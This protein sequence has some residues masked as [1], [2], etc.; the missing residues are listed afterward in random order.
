MNERIKTIL[1]HMLEDAVDVTDFTGQATSFEDFSGN[2]LLRKGVV[3]SLL[4]I[5]ELASHM[6]PDYIEAHSDV[7]WKEMIGMRNIAAHGYH[8]MNLEVI[9][10]TAVNSIPELLAFL[11][12]ELAG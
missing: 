1:E 7:P 9:W 3:M 5:G 8:F 12:K 11:E 4:N 10:Y 2:R 6:P